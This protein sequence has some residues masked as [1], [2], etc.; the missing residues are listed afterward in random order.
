[1][2]QLQPLIG[3]SPFEC[4][5]VGLVVALARAGALGVLDLGHDLAAAR[6]ALAKAGRRVGSPFGVRI[7]EHAFE[8]RSGELALPSNATVVVVPASALGLVGLIEGK[9]VLAQV[10][11]IDEA[12][13]AL[14]AGVHGLIV[15][16]N[17]AGGMVEE[18]TSFV[19]LQRVLGA[20]NAPIWVQGGIGLHTAAA[21]IAAGARGVVL[22]SQLALLEEAGT[23]P[24]LRRAL[25]T[26]DG[27]ETVVVGGYRLYAR[28][29]AK[30]AK[31]D[32]SPA[33][34]A[35]QLGATDPSTD[36]VTLGQDASFA[37]PFGQR[38]ASV[39]RLVRAVH[40]AFDGHVRQA[41]ALR[42]LARH[43]PLAESLGTVFPI[44]Q[45]PMT[46]VS[47]RAAFADE[48]AR[49]GGLPF[50]ALSL[51]RGPE[52]R[53][54]L[55]ETRRRLGDR[56]WGVGI[57]GFL[58]ADLREEQLA[59]LTEF[60][61]PVA[62]IAG[63]R[64]S[65]AKPLEDAGI[66][67]FLH[68]PSPGLL[69]LFLKDGARRF[70]FE[71]R[72]CG[73]HVGPRSSFVLWEAMIERLLARERLGD[74]TVV[75]AGGIH[76]AL[77][78]RMVAT[79][80]A[81]LAARGVQIGVL[82]GTA[83]LF[84]EEAVRCGAITEAFQDEALRCD[85]TALLE[86]APG[87][88][89]RCADSA[90][91]R[92][93]EQAREQLEREGQDPQAIW[94]A[95]EQ[96]NL[97]RLRIASKGL[98]REGDALVQVGDEEQHREGMFMVG[99]VA[100]L[101]SARCT[102][103]AL[104]RDVCD[105]STAQLDDVIVPAPP[106]SRER[107][108][109]DV[110][111]VGMACIFPDAP[112][113]ESFWTNILV[114]KNSVREVPKDRWDP[115][116]YFDP[117]GTGEKTPSKWGGFIPATVF[118]PGAYG[119]PPR[120]LAA[121]DPV[122]I[123]SLEVARRAMND[124]RLDER[125]FDRERASVVF[126]AEA[127]TD[128][129]NAYG[130]RA[131]I[132]RYIGEM[133]PA[134]DASL[135][136]LTEDSFP[137]VL[138]NVIAGRIANRLDLRG[139]NYTV[140]AA[141]ASS[142]AAVDVAC[143]EL[144]SGSSDIVVAGGADL[145]NGIHDFL[146]FASVHA[147]S[148]SGQS[149]PFDA[150]AD[151]I[152]LGEGI[153]AVVLKR[154]EDA[155]RD[156]DRVYAVLKGIG[157][158]SDGKS[159]GLTAPRKEGQIRALERAYV[160]ARTTPAKVGLVE[161]HG[162]GTVVGDRTELATLSEF[163]GA[164][165]A[166][167]EGCTLG[168]VKSQIGHTKC[169]AGLAGLIKA[170]LAVHHG[171]L[172]ATKN[173]TAP[174]PGYDAGTSPF[175]LR[176]RA[177]PWTDAERVAAVSAFGFG[178]TNF[179]AVLASHNASESKGVE[180]VLKEW[181][182]EII[183]CRGAKAEDVLSLLETVD[184]VCGSEVPPSLRDLAA[185]VAGAN[186]GAG[187]KLAIVATTHADLRAKISAF[188]EG[189][190]T[191]GVYPVA[192]SE[193]GSQVAFLFPGQ[194]SQRPGMLADL[195]V[196]FPELRD[197]LDLGRAFQGRMFP[198]AAFTPDARSA[199]QRAITDTRVAQPTLG[200][201]GLA[202]ARLL[203]RVGVTPAMMAGHSYGEL[204]ALAVA[205]AFDADS[206]LALSEARA[207][208]ILEAAPGAPGTMAAVRAS[209][210]KVASALGENAGVVIA[211]H[212]APDQVVIA[213][214]N[215]AVE[216]AVARLSQAGLS[217]KTIPVACAFHSPIVARARETF[218]A[219]LAAIDVVEP[220][221][222]VYA[223]ST[224]R[225]YVPTAEGVRT[226]LAE[227]VASPVRFVE[228]IEAMYAAGA[229][230]FVEVGP[231]GVLTDLV[232]RILRG[233]P[234]VAIPCDRSE[235]S[236]I[237]ALLT[238]L[239]RLVGA[240]VQ[241]DV[242]TLFHGRA[243]A[244]DLGTPA[245]F[246]APPTAWIVDGGGAR[247][248]RGELPD[249]AMRP[250]AAPVSLVASAAAPSPDAE[251][252]ST[253]RDYLRTMR[254]LVDAQREV[255]LR[256][257]GDTAPA[258]RSE[259]APRPSVVEDAPSTKHLNGSAGANG[260][261]T[262]GHAGHA[263]PAVAID[264]AARQGSPIVAKSPLEVLVATVSERTGYPADMLD[265]DLDLEADLGIDS[266][267]RI[268]ILGEMREK[269]GLQMGGGNGEAIVEELAL[270]KTLRGIAKLLEAHLDPGKAAGSHPN[271]A[272]NGVANG[273]GVTNGAAN[274]SA[275]AHANGAGAANGLSG[276]ANAAPASVPPPSGVER[277]VVEIESV[278]PPALS[279]S[280]AVGGKRFA[281]IGDTLGIGSELVALLIANDASARLV[282]PNEP[283]GKIDGLVH[284]S[285]VSDAGGG[286]RSLFTR[287]Q[288][289]IHA[290]A[291]WVIA[292]TGFGGRFGHHAH[293]RGGSADAGGVAGLLKSLS[294]EHP[295]AHVRAIDLDSSDLP[296][297][298]AAQIFEEIVG[299]DGHLE[300]GY[301]GGERHKLVVASRPASVPPPSPVE[302]NG[303]SVVLFTGG[304]RG[305]TAQIAIAM[306]RRFHC[307]LELV[308]RSPLPPDEEDS[309]MRAAADA[310]S[311]R[312]LLI[313]RVNGAGPA[314]PQAI[315][316]HCKQILAAREIHATLNAI[317]AAG[318]R[319]DYHAVDVRDDEAFGALIDRLRA[320]HGRIDGVVHGAGLIEDK[321]IRDKTHESF[322]RVF[323]TKVWGARTLAK[324][325][326]DETRFFVFFSS[327]SGAFG[328]RGQTD[329]AAANDALD[330]LAHQ[331]H[332][333]VRGRVLSINWGPWR[334]VGMVRPELER[335]YERR[336]IA[337]IQPDEGIARFFEELLGGS[338]PQVI[339]TA[340][341][342]EALA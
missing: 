272:A 271:G 27:S 274:G 158:S 67:T 244:V 82:M 64:P 226:T 193:G 114:G 316:A 78:A 180:P 139:V 12:R 207:N 41:R 5:D 201:A 262:N 153:A 155:E 142:L 276:D 33:Q 190:A 218:G 14:A 297:R 99:Q 4:P 279:P 118:D 284:L 179:H 145:H 235:G 97:G 268:E 302:I 2:S 290:N 47:D 192:A 186:R 143:K 105:G 315:D 171:V 74:V 90:F 247:P 310:P 313:S 146:M 173:V 152:A 333:S 280:L 219:H 332:G 28:P 25:A 170:A 6:E 222:P 324:R 121:I 301:G 270:V 113:L 166:V 211:N 213:G 163:F 131:S 48:V 339:L 108:V 327:V 72:E 238:A 174:N 215:E 159:L 255:M 336:G 148:K 132:P 195:F 206:L 126:G 100:A 245:R 136:K 63:G 94:A 283:L 102:I 62:L 34:I 249:F 83:Y 30:A 306:A 103:D 49:G 151:G 214:S 91:V 286:V 200:M 269:L 84:T 3:I 162:T 154:L 106:A 335:E 133:P 69:D 89:T 124:A 15:K 341:S 320:R 7:P 312:R 187:I 85:R 317:R 109:V 217:A 77:S 165:G 194:G 80:A 1:M 140:D 185:S 307:T 282:E 98:R 175:V 240:G 220:V 135:P 160:R 57:L 95:L 241:L 243:R 252:E 303:S 138:S 205:G 156:G 278:P 122:Q 239:G 149:R 134:L 164:A 208:C 168:S 264:A 52:A 212:N 116:Q 227:Q 167:A 104:H 328:N 225:P 265:P 68:V 169:A 178:G 58:P 228:E 101:R 182:A 32:D 17:E 130:F 231:G 209:G 88:A 13:A 16:G 18:E 314:S 107:A 11:T 87:H 36:L 42:P 55:E 177:V 325:L 71:G 147:L 19:L 256:F 285:T 110:A 326:A 188:R 230:V 275:H 266:I 35:A 250:L 242:E 304:A 44:V 234:H 196:A 329:Y 70:V 257:L 331:L 300:V 281:I 92:A 299:G 184:R 40:M 305:I 54:L 50:L 79:L 254:D 251:R 46:R 123:L 204:V 322:D 8:G 221:I 29:N 273:A 65:Q 22:D 288:E 246:A 202:L 260:K 144:A 237:T 340:A 26:M 117:S 137:G 112:D 321:L 93:F 342:A 45:G 293:A 9:T 96:L 21:C 291:H 20:T 172:P 259:R 308:G 330:K 66:A 295:S 223:N 229:R 181:P 73:G 323:S 161:A 129:A 43:A 125:Y 311:L 216:Q 39:E 183:V 81:P 51:M 298:L 120:S 296:A 24:A 191:D 334:G 197:L 289:A 199:Q 263:V 253:V 76:D 224:A 261:H 337:L 233:R 248:V 157:G 59:L 236:G 318:S 10:R 210:E 60:R 128:L 294:K 338:D 198:G 319:V 111:I 56:P 86:T 292:A 61:P 31:A 119:I 23:S 203:E 309:E 150:N 287:A 141:C 53:A 115:D 189:R 258:P 75:F 267:K 37:A 277:Y 176:D 127:G 232:G 38:F